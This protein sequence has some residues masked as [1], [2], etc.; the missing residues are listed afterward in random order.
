MQMFETFGVISCAM[1]SQLSAALQNPLD[2]SYH[3]A[4]ERDPSLLTSS[5]PLVSSHGDHALKPPQVP[6][7]RQETFS[8]RVPGHERDV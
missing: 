7:A 1:V 3:G 4:L 5:T 8:L 6:Q 2:D